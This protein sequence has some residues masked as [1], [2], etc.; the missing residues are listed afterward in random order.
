MIYKIIQKQAIED[1]FRGLQ[2]SYD[3]VVGPQA[4]GPAF[5]FDKLQDADSL[6]LDYDST[7]LPPTKYFLPAD[8]RLLRFNRKSGEVF[9]TEPTQITRAIFGMHPCDIN[10]LLLLDEIFMGDYLDP[11]YVAAR[12]STF[13]IGVSCMPGPGHICN[14]FGTDEIHRGFDIFLTDLDDRYFFSCR[15]VPAAELIDKY[16]DTFEP[17][18]KDISDFQERTNRFKT[19]FPKAPK[20]DQLPLIYG[21]KYNDDALWEELGDD[22]LCCGACSMVCPVCYCF[23]VCDTLD[24]CGKMGLRHRV[25]DSCLKS[26]FAEVAH[27][28]NFRPT[29]ASRVRYRFFHKFVGNFSRSGKMLCVGCGRCNKSCKVGITPARVIERLQ[30]E[31]HH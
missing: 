17:S 5:V 26:E 4:R 18:A 8:E 20:M 30:R 6:R 28:H 27:N 14:A 13:I 15:S 10:A 22:C 29:R 19:A 1:L 3:E 16:L 9:D 25:W 2:E 31:T 23:D 12:K 24:A 21:A 7:I 11:Y